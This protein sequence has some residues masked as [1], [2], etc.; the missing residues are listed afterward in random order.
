MPFFEGKKPLIQ[1]AFSVSPHP[2]PPRTSIQI[3]PSPLHIIG[4]ICTIGKIAL[5]KTSVR[6]FRLQIVF[7]NKLLFSLNIGPTAGGKNLMD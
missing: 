6:S 3:T 5:Q 7:D 1:I 2:P 4:L